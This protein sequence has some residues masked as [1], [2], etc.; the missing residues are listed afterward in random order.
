MY[1]TDVLIVGTRVAVG[2]AAGLV[3]SFLTGLYCALTKQIR[4]AT[5]VAFVIFAL[6][7]ITMATATKDSSTNVWGYPVFMGFGLGMT[8]VLLVTVAQ[9][10]T[11]P[12]LIASASGLIIAVRSLGGTIGIAICKSDPSFHW[13]FFYDRFMY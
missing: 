3:A 2:Y 10:S 7:F 11:P 13:V 5:F 1:D 6:F 12:E 4:W 8:L 9:L